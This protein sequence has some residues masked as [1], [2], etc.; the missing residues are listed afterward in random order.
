MVVL[1]PM[2]QSFPQE[3]KSCPLPIEAARAE[4]TNGLYFVDLGWGALVVPIRQGP[5]G[6]KK[7]R[8]DSGATGGLG[9]VAD[10]VRHVRRGR[11]R[12]E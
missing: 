10:A 5:G 3:A 9:L 2:A 1:G 4:P 12:H 11:F 8:Q 7:R 6:A